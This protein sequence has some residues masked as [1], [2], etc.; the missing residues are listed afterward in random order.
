[1]ARVGLFTPQHHSFFLYYLSRVGIESKHD[2]RIYA[3]ERV[4]DD[5]E[6]LYTEAE[7]S[8]ISWVLGRESESID[9]FFNRV[10]ANSTELDLL[11][12]VLAWGTERV[13]PNLVDFDPDPPVF[14]GITNL[15]D[16]TYNPFP[17][18]TYKI[19]N[20][21]TPLLRDRVDAERTSTVF[22]HLRYLMQPAIRDTF[23]AIH[24]EYPPMLR[25]IE[26]EVE[27]EQPFLEFPPVVFEESKLPAVGQKDG[28]RIVVP[29]RISQQIRNVELL[30]DA[31]DAVFERYRGDL[32]LD[33]VGRLTGDYET[34]LARIE[35]LKDRGY[36][37]RYR[38][39]WIPYDEFAAS[40][41]AG[42]IIVNPLHVRRTISHPFRSDMWTGRTNGTGPI[43]DALRYA[44]PLVVPELFPVDDRLE[45][46]TETYDNA[47]HLA[48][49]LVELLSN[50]DQLA[51]LQTN[52]EQAARQVT[53]EAQRPRFESIV[54]QLSR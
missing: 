40:L 38:E 47:D 8:Q 18:W 39:N 6:E 29:G 51:E 54:D 30:L 49:L 10:E 22:D 35:S 2:I 32:T 19:V 24:I 3:P 52:A 46:F 42:D 15:N 17:N 50:E 34:A 53:P 27:W 16:W 7:H 11:W 48:D 25:F 21:V 37:V 41:R 5:I 36:D 1:M 44:R 9:E 26:N 31:M 13:P 12:T 4:H 33:F 20:T 28:P 14:A 43:F 45:P 23:D